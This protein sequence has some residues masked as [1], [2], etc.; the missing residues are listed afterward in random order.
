MA[1]LASAPVVRA[2]TDGRKALI[3]KLSAIE[4]LELAERAQN[5]LKAAEGQPK[6]ELIRANQ[7]VSCD[8]IASCVV[9]TTWFGLRPARLVYQNAE[10]AARDL[11]P[12]L[13]DELA[14]LVAEVNGI[15]SATS[16]NP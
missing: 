14:D 8:L 9:T 6:I 10:A 11:S 5:T 7:L 16:P 3:R 2:L 4:R 13:V 15:R 1:S 12:D